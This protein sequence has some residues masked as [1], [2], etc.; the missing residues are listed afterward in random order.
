MIQRLA[1]SFL[2]FFFPILSVFSDTVSLKSG[3]EYRN[4]KTVLGKKVVIVNT[5][6]GKSF[7]VPVADI[8][9]IK[10]VPVKWT[11]EKSDEQEF[12]EQADPFKDYPISP[13]YPKKK[14]ELSLF[15]LTG[16]I[17]V[18]SPAYKM[19]SSLG[20]PIG[21]FFSISELFLTGAL[22]SHVANPQKSYYSD[23]E[24]I[25]TA[26]YA[27]Y[28]NL[29]FATAP[30]FASLYYVNQNRHLVKG[31]NGN[32]TTHTLLQEDVDRLASGLV[33]LLIVDVIVN[34]AL[35][36]FLWRRRPI[37]KDLNSVSAHTEGWRFTMRNQQRSD[38]E[39]L[40]H[41]GMIGH[42]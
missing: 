35:P 12:S 9:Y 31:P 14:P 20:T 27:L 42:F 21:V 29:D 18:W 17:P 23:S 3:Q 24:N 41:F 37:P 13:I 39:I 5:E 2:L 19:D 40:Y 10:S 34:L 22:I 1:A 8:K 4:V 32:Y 26:I 36:D 6:D 28:P 25:I 30:N 11:S 33:I 15:S 38:G 7:N 16:F